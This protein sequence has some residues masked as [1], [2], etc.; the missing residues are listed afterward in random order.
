MSF[1][2]HSRTNCAPHCSRSLDG[3]RSCR[4]EIWPKE[5]LEEGLEVIGR[6]AKSQQHIIEDLLDMNRILS[7]KV[8]LD[9]QR[10]ELGTVLEAALE[11]V[12]PAAQA[13]GVKIH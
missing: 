11:T 2:R 3:C 13:K 1:L 6:N 5:K 4:Q 7:G 9:V 12:R 10:V 8:R